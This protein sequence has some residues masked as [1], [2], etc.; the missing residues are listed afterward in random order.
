[1][2]LPLNLNITPGEVW[3]KENIDQFLPSGKVWEAASP[4]LSR[5]RS[6]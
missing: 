4:L 1:M 3:I 5:A 2:I 6:I